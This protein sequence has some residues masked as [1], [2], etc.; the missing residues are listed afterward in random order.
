MQ[1]EKFEITC[2][3]QAGSRYALNIPNSKLLFQLT[4]MVRKEYSLVDRLPW[5]RSRC[6]IL[7]HKNNIRFV[8]LN[9]ILVFRLFDNVPFGG[10]FFL[11]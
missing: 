4:K 8:F 7:P 9:S 11:H 5:N 2:R 10:K 6:D 1:F 3:R